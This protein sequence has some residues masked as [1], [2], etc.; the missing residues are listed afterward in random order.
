MDFEI[1]SIKRYS[2]LLEGTNSKLSFIR[3]RNALREEKKRVNIKI[4]LGITH[5]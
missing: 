4:F 2:L 5:T 3:P 1:N